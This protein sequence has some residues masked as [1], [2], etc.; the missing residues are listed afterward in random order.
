MNRVFFLASIFSTI[1]CCSFI[2]QADSMVSDTCSLPQNNYY[3]ESCNNKVA[4]NSFSYE[5]SIWE[6]NKEEEYL[7]GIDN[8]RY[9]KD[10]EWGSMSISDKV[11][12]EGRNECALSN[13]GD[14]IIFDND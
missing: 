6:L 3:Y 9:P 4:N 1:L 11:R 8:T 14:C 5:K 10:A 13:E 12:N 7:I 2:V